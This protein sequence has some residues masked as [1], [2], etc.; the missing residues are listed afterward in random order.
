M[1]LSPVIGSVCIVH[2]ELRQQWKHRQPWAA[3]TFLLLLE[4]YLVLKVPINLVGKRL[5]KLITFATVCHS[6]YYKK[7]HLV[8]CRSLDVRL[9]KVP[10]IQNAWGPLVWRANHPM[11]G[12]SL[13]GGWKDLI[14]SY[15]RFWADLIKKQQRKTC[16]KSTWSL[17]SSI[18][19]SSSL[20]GFSTALDL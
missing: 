5:L 8:R 7:R 17:P 4:N 20:N 16:P 10:L 3:G 9:Q 14:I 2:P 18:L 15:V 13:F 19:P 1:Y 6:S 12:Q 11:N